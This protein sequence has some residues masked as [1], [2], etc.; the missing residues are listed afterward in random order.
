MVR[1]RNYAGSIKKGNIFMLNIQTANIQLAPGTVTYKGNTL[2]ETAG[3]INILRE[4]KVYNVFCDSHAVEPTHSSIRGVK[5]EISMTLVEIDSAMDL[6][7]D[8]NGQLDRSI[9]GSDIRNSAG[10][11]IITT[12]EN[13]NAVSY[14]FPNAILSPDYKCSMT[15]KARM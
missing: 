6:F 3:P 8:A 15:T 1:A 14:K 5:M 13:G 12:T 7:L 4:T 9:I 2:G 11:L 10:E